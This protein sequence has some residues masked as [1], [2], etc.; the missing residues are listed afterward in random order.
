MKGWLNW[1]KSTANWLNWMKS[2]ANAGFT[3]WRFDYVKG[4]ETWVIKDMRAAT[5]NPFTVGE[6][7][8]SNTT[9]LDNW[10]NATGSSAFDFALYYTFKD[11]CNNTGGG[12][13]LPN[14][15]NS[16]KSFVAK[17]PWKAVT[18]VGNHDT[19]EIIT[20]KM[21]AYAFILTYKGYPSIYWKD[22]F[23]YGL[24]T[25]GGQWGNGIKH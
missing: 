19:D 4:L 10:A 11:I 5:G 13:Y 25:V 24:A 23:N 18:F 22:Y 21:L 15:F 6:L 12:G 7:W 9:I 1:M 20:D 3:G 17:N 16:T 14:V 2:T 8:D